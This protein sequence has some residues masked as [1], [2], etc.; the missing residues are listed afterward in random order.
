M[1][2]PVIDDFMNGRRPRR[3]SRS[4]RAASS[5]GRPDHPRGEEPR[6]ELL[7]ASEGLF[8]K[9]EFK[10]VKDVSFKLPKGKTLGLVGESGSGKT[11]VGPHADA[12][13]R[14]HQRRGAVRGQGHPRDVAEREFM[15]YKRRIQIIFQNPYASLN[16][17]FTVGQILTEPMKIHGIGADDAGAHRAGVRAA[18]Q[19][20]ACPRSRS[21]STRT[22]SRAASASA[23]RS[24]AASR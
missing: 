14:G 8:G 19:G 2:L 3:T 12:P 6:Q 16:P 21:T 5:P 22:S 20:R 1:R 24:R 9:R 10:A 17:R 11:T 13:A 4:A 7:P 23:S 18:R 15:A